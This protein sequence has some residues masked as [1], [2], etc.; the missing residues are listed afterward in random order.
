MTLFIFHYHLNPGGVTRIIDLQIDALKLIWPGLSICIVAGDCPDTSKYEKKDISIIVNPDLDYLN[1]STEL[2]SGKFNRIHSFIKRTCSKNDILHFHNLNLGKNPLLT[3][4]VAKLAYEG[5]NIINHAHDFSEDRPHNQFF[6]KSIIE[7]VFHESLQK[8]MYPD[9]NNFVIVVLN[10]FDLIRLARNNIGSDRCYLLP[11]PVFLENKKSEISDLAIRK[12]IVE[13]LNLCESKLIITYPVRVI[14]RKNIAEFVLLATL[15]QDIAN[16][17][18]TQPPKNPKEIEEY[19]KWKEFCT[20]ENISIVWEAGNQVNFEQLIQIS[21]YCITTSIQEGFGMV[22]LEPWLLDTPVIGRDL[23]MITVDL[24]SAG[25]SFPF[26]Y[27][28]LFVSDKK[29]IHELSFEGQKEFIRELKKSARL[30]DKLL[31][32][33]LFLNKFPIPVNLPLIHKN[34]GVILREYSLEKYGQRLNEIYR[35]IIK[36]A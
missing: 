24:M 20:D 31:E 19:N 22:Y 23:P 33:N 35:R 11:N 29:E 21:D 10:S 36:R 4:A 3:L 27:T 14:R 7:D 18:V 6:L 16:W 30:K 17:V 34:K 2:L 25:V 8:I 12:N 26:L 5:F 9:L 15:F 28:N 1:D 32:M 13:K